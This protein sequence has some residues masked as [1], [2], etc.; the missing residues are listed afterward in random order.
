MAQ[1]RKQARLALG[2][3]AA[4]TAGTAAVLG[5][6]QP[7]SASSVN[8]DAVAQCESGGNWSTNT[9]NGFS[10]GLQFT[11]STWKAYGGTKYA[12]SAHQAS[13]A[14]QIAVAERVLHGQ[15]IKAW[16]VCGGRAGSAKKYTA[17]NTSGASAHKASS[18]KA[19]SHKASVHKTTTKKSTVKKSTASKSTQHRVVRSQGSKVLGAHARQYVVRPGDTLSAIAARNHVAGG[20]KALYRLNRQVVGGNPNLI[21]PGQ[22][23]AL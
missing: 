15:G 4:T 1:I 5:A 16:P 2:I 11:R 22:H 18:H 9:G 8:W 6:A 19:S 13:R 3:V 21:L 20:W 17:K 7:A 23:L 10:G 14:Q 12:P